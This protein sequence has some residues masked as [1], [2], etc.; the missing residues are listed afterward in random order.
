MNA[1]MSQPRS[2][3]GQE[4]ASPWS[5]GRAPLEFAPS[6]SHRI[7][8]FATPRVLSTL[9]APLINTYMC[10]LHTASYATPRDAIST[11]EARSKIDAV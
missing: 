7:D 4:R 3:P 5:A 11:E 10:R 6:Q 1:E 2:R 9:N 8:G